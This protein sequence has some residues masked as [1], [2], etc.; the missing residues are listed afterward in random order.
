MEL[1]STPCSEN[2][3][4]L[5]LENTR[6]LAEKL[7]ARY[8]VASASSPLGVLGAVGSFEWDFDLPDHRMAKIRERKNV[9]FILLTRAR[10]PA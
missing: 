3:S 9:P 2:D 1:A 5:Q 7:E 6:K 8:L 10:A 4:G